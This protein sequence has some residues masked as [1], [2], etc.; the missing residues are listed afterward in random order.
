MKHTFPDLAGWS[1]EVDEVS[2]GVYRVDATDGQGRQISRS[3]TDPERLI[4]EC[5][6]E[7]HS[8]TNTDPLQ[9][10]ISG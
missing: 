6:L 9:G 7:A 5:R 8:M 2:A 10:R 3:G 4:D 1:F